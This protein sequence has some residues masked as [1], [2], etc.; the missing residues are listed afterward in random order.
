MQPTLRGRRNR[1]EETDQ[2]SND[3]QNRVM[4]QG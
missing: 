3:T 2:E 4:Q 1:Q